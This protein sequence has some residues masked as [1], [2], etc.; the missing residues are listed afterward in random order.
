[1]DRFRFLHAGGVM[2]GSFLPGISSIAEA[3]DLAPHS[4]FDW[5]TA[6]GPENRWNRRRIVSLNIPTPR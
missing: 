2:L 5:S 1:M 6:M 3:A 4:P